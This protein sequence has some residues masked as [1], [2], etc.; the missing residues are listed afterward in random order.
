MEKIKAT[1]GIF[2]E[3][4]AH[5]GTIAKV[6]SSERKPGMKYVDVH[7]Q[8]DGVTSADGK[9]IVIKDGY[10]VGISPGTALGQLLGRFLGKMVVP[11]ESYDPEEI[12]KGKKAAFLTMNQEVP[13]KGKFARIA[14]GSLKPA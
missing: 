10:P 8:V 9:P 12:L 13:N 11:G 4:G 5:T 14:D 7:V 2:I 1:S 3:D 6:E